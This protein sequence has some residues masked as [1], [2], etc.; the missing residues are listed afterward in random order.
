MKSAAK[1]DFDHLDP[2]LVL[3][4]VERVSPVGCTNICRPLNSYINRVYEVHLR[5]ETQVIAKFYRPGR[6]SHDAL[7]DELDFLL[8]L[9][10]E[11]IPVI[12][13][14]ESEHG[15]HLH[16]HHG[17]YYALFP[18]K[19][20]RICDEPSEEQWQELGRLIGRVHLV[21]GQREPGDRIT[22]TPDEATLA[23]LEGILASGTVAPE[24]RRAFEQ[25]ARDILER[26]IPLFKDHERIRIH[27]DLHHQNLI[28]RPD[29]GFYII[30]FD[31]MANGLP[32]QD[33][34]MLLPG[35]VADTQREL[36]LF[37][38]G[39]E[40]FTA[41]DYATLKLVE[42]LRAMRFIH[43]LAWCVRQQEDGGFNRLAP[44]FGTPS[45]WAKEVRELEKQRQE[46]EDV[47]GNT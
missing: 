14:I 21:G 33:I 12:A 2:D 11:E 27:G 3:D 15:Q 18:K 25:T 42:P 37:L 41:F 44:D 35:R 17:M 16:Q 30:D 7:L 40:T 20:G 31:D 10:E 45:F 39:Y 9:D 29:E 13:P 8:D 5:D 28:Y 38:D 6:W 26:I 46:I 22:L 23:Q 36:D 19:G 24:Y 43:F 47:L 34:W 4:L 32:I 1:S